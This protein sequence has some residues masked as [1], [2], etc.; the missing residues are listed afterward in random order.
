MTSSLLTNC[1][2]MVIALNKPGFQQV[3]HKRERTEKE[4]LFVC[5]F[6]RMWVLLENTAGAKISAV[7][8]Y[9]NWFYRLYMALVCEQKK[10]NVSLRTQR[11]NVV[12]TGMRTSLCGL[13]YETSFKK[14]QLVHFFK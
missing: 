6:G 5:G 9:I 14:A 11:H 1:A 7:L 12:M 13:Y 8:M 4:G 3:K 2:T 10:S